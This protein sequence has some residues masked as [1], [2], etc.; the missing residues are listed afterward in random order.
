MWDK[1]L[2][3][4]RIIIYVVKVSKF[5]TYTI[6]YVHQRML[7]IK[8]F[9]ADGMSEKDLRQEKGITFALATREVKKQF[10]IPG[11][12]ARFVVELT[13][14]IVYYLDSKGKKV[15]FSKATSE[16]CFSDKS[17]DK[18]DDFYTDNN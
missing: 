14:N 10:N 13:Y 17:N 15:P 3:I 11:K 1:A 6:P 5:V 4:M 7:V 18:K 16:N 8:C 2:L 12:V 9:E